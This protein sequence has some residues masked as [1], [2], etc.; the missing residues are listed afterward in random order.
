MKFVRPHFGQARL[1][2]EMGLVMRFSRPEDNPLPAIR[3]SLQYLDN[4]AREYS[5]SLKEID[6]SIVDEAEINKR[7]FR[8]HGLLSMAYLN[9]HKI[10][11]S[12][13]H[14]FCNEDPLEESLKFAKEEIELRKNNG[15]SEGHDLMNAYH[16]Y[17]RALIEKGIATRENRPYIGARHYLNEAMALTDNKRVRTVLTFRHAWLDFNQREGSGGLHQSMDNLTLVI[18]NQQHLT[19]GD[20]NVLKKELFKMANFFKGDHL[21]GVQG[22][23]F[24]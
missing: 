22:M 23:Y 9:V 16:T 10:G 4:A 21:K 5:F 20:R 11:D 19:D 7:S 14:P 13:G 12:G 15:E 2:E 24:K 6:I 18:K 8:I 3:E 1:H 17:A